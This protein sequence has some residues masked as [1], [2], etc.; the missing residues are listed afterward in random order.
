MMLS[1]G[2][3]HISKK[4]I[5]HRDL[6]ARNI[7][8]RVMGK[9]DVLVK[10]CDFGLGRM[11]DG[12]ENYY[13]VS[14]KQAAMPI[15]WSAPEALE[16]KKF[17]AKS[18]VFSFGVV[19]WEVWSHGADPYAEWPMVSILKRIKA[20][21]RLEYPFGCSQ[22]IYD[23]MLECWRI[24]PKDRPDWEQLYDRLEAELNQEAQ[25][26]VE[27]G[28]G[29][30]GAAAF[31]NDDENDEQGEPDGAYVDNEEETNY[32]AELDA[33]GDQYANP[34]APLTER[35]K[36]YKVG[37]SSHALKGQ[38]PPPNAA[39]YA[40][41]KYSVKQQS[42]DYQYQEGTY[43]RKPEDRVS[44]GPKK[45]SKKPL[46]PLPKPPSQ[47]ESPTPQRASQGEEVKASPL[48]D[49][50]RKPSA[51]PRPNPRKLAKNQQY[52]TPKKQQQY[53]SPK[54]VQQQYA[55]QSQQQQYAS[56]NQLQY[57][58]SNQQQYVHPQQYVVP[59]KSAPSPQT[60]HL[61]RNSGHSHAL[62]PQTTPSPPLN[63]SHEEYAVQGGHPHGHP[64]VQ[65]QYYY[66]QG[67]PPPGVPPQQQ[68][69]QYAMPVAQPYTQM[70]MQ[71]DQLRHSGYTQP[72]PQ[73]QQ[74]GYPG[75]YVIPQQPPPLYSQGSSSGFYQ[76]QHSPHV[77][78]VSPVVASG[79]LTGSMGYVVPE[80]ANGVPK[81]QDFK[82]RI[83]TKFGMMYM[84]CGGIL[85]ANE[86]A[87]GTVFQ[88]VWSKSDP[89][90]YSIHVVISTYNKEYKQCL[91]IDHNGL[92]K[93]H[94]NSEK[95]DYFKVVDD[96]ILHQRTQKYLSFDGKKEIRAGRDKI[97]DHERVKF[98]RVGDEI[99]IEPLK[100]D[101]VSSYLHPFKCK[102]R[103]K[104]HK[105]LLGVHNN[106]GVLK[107]LAVAD[108]NAVAFVEKNEIWEFIPN[109]ACSAYIIRSSIDP[110]MYLFS[111]GSDHNLLKVHPASMPNGEDAN[112]WIVEGDRQLCALKSRKNNKYVTAETY[113]LRCNRDTNSDW[114][115]MSLEV[116]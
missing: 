26:T 97:K 114:E 54:Q 63:R 9:E 2:M 94:I 99:V 102:I 104:R 25:A 68:H 20:G 43:A 85:G 103:C 23:L 39:E 14:D 40:G 49:Q 12:G 47:Y 16:F 98:V 51:S 41:S 96:G 18:D 61:G 77:M 6:A 115:K 90:E 109:S 79:N 22:N 42:S 73:Q 50:S 72:Y 13:V 74:P 32:D 113:A 89:D 53:A 101:P 34:S 91:Y 107:S 64:N 111:E 67:S 35:E 66:Q 37:V 31:E 24:E 44:G 70:P 46:K 11:L 17:S 87:S 112:E 19:M 108:K 80:G 60:Q 75:A 1:V 27:D 100:F 71:G 86:K 76:P 10:L 4:G 69:H 58:S 81:E 84:T 33:G 8:V 3:G 93:C 92:L 30:I 116:E 7:L 110:N 45:A 21:E 56:A 59:P 105:K 106:K 57:A 5:L 48:L 83:K 38:F 36:A 95:L 29:A 65:S 52:A 88:F 55:N 28:Y 82:C 78:P 62:P 15:K